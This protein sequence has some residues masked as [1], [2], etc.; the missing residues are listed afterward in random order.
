M[1]LELDENVIAAYVNNKITLLL[2]SEEAPDE[3]ALK[4][5]L[6]KEK[7]TLVSLMK[8]GEKPKKAGEKP[9]APAPEKAA[10]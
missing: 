2:R 7:I 4:D 5:Q 9:A 6:T 10:Q 3:Q 8:A 1:A